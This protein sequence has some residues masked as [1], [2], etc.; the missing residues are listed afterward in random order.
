[1]T[2]RNFK[3]T[4]ALVS[5]LT[6]GVAAESPVLAGLIMWS[7]TASTD[8]EVGGA[9]GNWSGSAIPANNIL[10]TGDVAMFNSAVGNQPTL[11]A[12]RSVAG[13]KF[14]NPAAGG[15]NLGGAFTLTLGNGITNNAYG[16][17]SLNTSGTNTVSATGLTFGANQAW[18]VASGGT[19]AVSSAIGQDVAG[20]TL[21]LSGGG[22]LSLSGSNSYT[23]LTTISGSTLTL[24]AGAGGSM[25]ATAPLTLS[26]TTSTF[27]YDNTGAG[28]AVAQT[29]G[30]LTFS[31][32]E[33]TIQTNRVVLQPV[34]LTLG[35]PTRTAGAT[36][37]FVLGGTPGANGTDSQIQLTKAAGFID[38]G[39]FFG[40]SSY[41]WMDGLNT[42]V[43]G[44]NYGTDGTTAT[45]AGATSLASIAHQQITGSVTAEANGQTFT[46]F[47]IAG[48]YDFTL[49]G[50]AT[51]TVNG[52][53]KTGAG[54]S[55]ISGGSG[56]KAANNAELVIRTNAA[57]DALTVSTPILVSGTS[58]L[59]K[60]GPGTLTL[61]AAN[62]YT[63]ATTLNAG[64]LNLSNSLALQSST[65]NGSAGS[66]VFD[67]SVGSHAF[68]FGALSGSV[69]I[70]LT[71]NGG[72]AVALT[73]GG[74]NAVASYSSTLSGAGSL[75]KTGTGAM[76]L[77]GVNTYTGGT[78]IGGTGTVAPYTGTIPGTSIT[79]NAG[80]KIQTTGRATYSLS[81]A[82]AD[83]ALV[84]LGGTWY[85]DADS[86]G[87]LFETV[88]GVAG[89]GA[90]TYSSSGGKT[91]VLAPASGNPNFSGSFPA[92]S[93]GV[94]IAVV[95]S[96]LGGQTLSGTSA[97]PGSLSVHAGLLTLDAG[98][99]GTVGTVA[100]GF[101]GGTFKY[102][103][104]TALGP[105][106]QTL[107]ALTFSAGDGTV[108]STRTTLQT[109]SLTFNSLAARTAGAT[110]NFV[111]D[112]NG[113]ANGTDNKIALTGAALGYI[114]Q[115]EFF[116]G[117]NYAYMN[118][119]GG[120]VRAPAYGTDSGFVTSG[121][122]TS[123]ASATHQE[124]TGD[125]TAQNTATFTTLKIA[126][127]DILAMANPSQVVTVNGILKTGGGEGRIR[128]GTLKAGAGTNT[129]L[130]IRTAEATDWLGVTSQ[131]VPNGANVNALTKSGP[132]T[133]RLN[134][135]VASTYTGATT[136]NNGVLE[137]NRLADGGVDS[138]IGKSANTA[139]SLVL[140]GGTL[141]FIGAFGSPQS[142]NRLFTL[143]AA[144]GTLDASG[145]GLADTLGF[146]NAGAIAYVGVGPRILTLT[147]T[148]AGANTLAPI[149]GDLT[150]SVIGITALKSGA[151]SLVK[152]GPGSWTL[153]AING[154]SGTT[155]VSDGTLIVGASDHAAM[156]ATVTD[157]VNNIITVTG[158]GASGMSANQTVMFPVPTANPGGLDPST[159]YYIRDI[160]GDTFKLAGTPGGTVI[161]ITSA[162]SGLT[163]EFGGALGV[164]GAV[165]IDG[166]KL[167]TAAGVTFSREFTFTSGKIGG[168]GTFAEAGGVTV[169]VGAYL[170]PGLS[171]GVTTFSAGLAINGAYTWELNSETDV[172]GAAP[173]Y[174]FD[175]AMVSGGSLT[176][177]AGATLVPTFL[178]TG[179]APS[180][181]P[182]WAA[183]HDW[184]IIDGPASGIANFDQ[185]NITNDWTTFGQFSTTNAGGDVLLHWAP[186]PEP[187]T[188]AFL[189]FG[190]LAMIGAGIRRRRT[191]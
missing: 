30:A 134:P 141:R 123:L 168:N 160:S 8:F 163:A 55:T 165:T 59:T 190:G 61:S 34:T 89:T 22:T 172:Q 152:D 64:T 4:L 105:K 182:F 148:N 43:R 66:V 16:I 73:V 174:T 78:T 3:L 85:W 131:I 91:L 106:S 92:T 179:V 19:L 99:G 151:T 153:S 133:L 38:Q 2:R 140:N 54:L 191:A 31:A 63:G 98:A 96:G 12:S 83:T 82:I 108:Q 70:S 33:G 109:V 25:A 142:T 187:A 102:D 173:N 150:T 155:T 71:D 46:T 24:A 69:P 20:R 104:T 47:K 57:T 60:S 156:S 185:G 72:N 6:I 146:T 88:G 189:A 178:G 112:L 169:P 132:G 51:T 176:I 45:S 171:A 44:I 126:G 40:G 42:F 81:N 143:G 62:T 49:A 154:Y 116:G 9:G 127:A 65:F 58:S 32:G 107:G 158:F 130:V 181:D 35:A 53:L 37:N 117:D 115:G 48:A 87:S 36:G 175:Q 159:V 50:G 86:T 41:A 138:A 17:Q 39:T 164:H 157:L 114:N 94:N 177:D 97:G 118:S 29:L 75:T 80:A 136:I 184:L 137:V 144:G 27:N 167:A 129:E 170:D 23:G 120:F 77:Y 188:M 21:T 7:G 145:D 183:A 166:G 180:A 13:L 10:T 149:I 125:I 74:N 119:A 52:I 67:S 79:I 28:G 124:I 103:N 11:T 56:I 26:G 15:W 161:D 110:G 111:V 101:N 18:Y 93:G 139:S 14:A 121:T 135:T 162:G 90:F 113:G 147:G 5:V 128:Y 68:T 76:N 186:V 122:T 95:K 1:M 100:L 84:T